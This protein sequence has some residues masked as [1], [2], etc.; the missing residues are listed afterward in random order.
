M[1][2]SFATR[3]GFPN[4]SFRVVA[5]S[6]SIQDGSKLT[7]VLVMPRRTTPG[8]PTDT[9]SNSPCPPAK[10]A[11]ASSRGSGFGG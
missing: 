4:R 10:E 7:A 1:S 8:K 9:R 2:A 6:K 5:R 3:T 11:M